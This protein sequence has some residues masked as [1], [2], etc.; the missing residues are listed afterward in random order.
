MQIMSYNQNKEWI[1]NRSLKG[2]RHRS[3]AV[4]ITTGT[5]E[6]V[7]AARLRLVRPLPRDTRSFPEEGLSAS[8]A[9]YC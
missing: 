8:E 2:T 7:A 5:T 4:F 3:D 1:A 9:H 6:V